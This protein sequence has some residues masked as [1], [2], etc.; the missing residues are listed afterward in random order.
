M[1]W[2][3][4]SIYSRINYQ[5]YSENH[6]EGS[7]PPTECLD[8]FPGSISISIN[9]IFLCPNFSFL[10]RNST[11]SYIFTS[12]ISRITRLRAFRQ[13]FRGARIVTSHPVIF[14]D[15]VR[16]KTNLQLAVTFIGQ[17]QTLRI[18]FYFTVLCIFI[19]HV[20]LGVLLTNSI[21]PLNLSLS[22]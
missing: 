3:S 15:S 14:Y 12:S 18:T 9:S 16:Q 7:F 1:S 2:V 21:W 22:I 19:G 10:F 8:Q 5:Q 6:H 4:W 17:S 13:Y 20:F 11:S